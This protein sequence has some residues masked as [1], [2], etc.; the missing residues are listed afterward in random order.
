MRKAVL[1]TF[2]LAGLCACS[3]KDLWPAEE[4]A[5]DAVSTTTTTSATV[6]PTSTKKDV[7]TFLDDDPA[8]T[9][10][11]ETSIA[12]YPLLSRAARNVTVSV[13][14]GYVTLGGSVESFS[15]RDQVHDLVSHIVRNEKIHDDLQVSPMSDVDDR[16]SDENIAFSLERSLVDQPRVTIDVRH[17]IV[18]LRGEATAPDV[19]MRMA[20]Q[21]P[22]VVAVTNYLTASAPEPPTS[23][24]Q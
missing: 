21:T 6:E 23:L 11:V 1:C 5:T 20:E 4:V 3:R 13:E 18:K 19:V 8:L 2:L 16:A 10:R 9:R 12:S 17:G 7:A 14:N 22:G 24:V 15:T